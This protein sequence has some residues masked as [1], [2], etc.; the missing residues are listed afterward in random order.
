[1]N[2]F[3]NY[4]EGLI[5]ETQRAIVNMETFEGTAESIEL[6]KSVQEAMKNGDIETLNKIIQEN[7]NTTN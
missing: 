3:S 5:H 4:I 7:G 1:M 6:M 2:E